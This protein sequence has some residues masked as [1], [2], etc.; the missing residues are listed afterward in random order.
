MAKA[1]KEERRQNVIDVLNK[2]RA[3][4]ENASAADNEDRS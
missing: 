2:A 1:S 3:M 4:E